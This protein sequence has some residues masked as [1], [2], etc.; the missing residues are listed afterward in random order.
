MK[1]S[2]LFFAWRLLQRGFFATRFYSLSGVTSSEAVWRFWEGKLDADLNQERQSEFSAQAAAPPDPS[3]T[4]ASRIGASPVSLGFA[5]CGFF[6]ALPFVGPKIG[7]GLI[8]A[9]AFHSRQ[10]VLLR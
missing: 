6:L 10:P 3:P 8:L 1:F 2:L 7:F 4:W 9:S 5:R